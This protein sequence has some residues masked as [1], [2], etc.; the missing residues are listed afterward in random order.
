M[1]VQEK[2][3]K[4]ATR[5]RADDLIQKHEELIGARRNFES[6]WQSLHD[7]FYLESA[8]INK[9]YYPGTELDP[10]FLWDATTIESADVFA[11]GFMN[12]LTPPT[13]KWF[14]LK[15]KNPKLSENKAIGDFLEGVA[16]EVN[17]TLNRSNFYD[18][19]FPSYKSSGVY[20]TSLILEEDD[21]QDSVRFYNL[22]LKQ[23]VICEDAR[24]RPIEYYIEFEYTALQASTR[25]GADALS[26]EMQQ[27]LKAR[28]SDK[29]H[30]FVLYIGKRNI[31]EV[32]KFD[33]KNMPIEAVWIDVKA[34]KIVEEG[35]YQEFPAMAH[36]F[37]KRPFCPWG[38]SPA[39]KALPFARILNTV[40]K[41]NLRAM[42]KQTDPPVALP[43]NAFIMP[44]NAN[45]RAINYYNKD[46]M[47]GGAKDIFA[48]S[49][50]GDPN[51]GMQATEY[52][53]Q[54]VKSLMYNDVF[55]A[56]QQITKDMN[57]PE[58]MERIN[59]KM[60]MLGPAV[61][62][63]LAEVLNP[64]I[65]RTI[66]I[67]F[68][69]GKLP[70]PP[71]EMMEDPAYEIDFV[72]QLAQAQRRSELN[73]LVTGMTMVGQMAAFAPDVLDKINPDRVTDEV[74]AITGAPV[75]VLRD[76]QEIAD[77]RAN[78][79]E[80]EAKVQEMQ[81]MNAG[82]EVAMKAGKGTESFAK[83]KEVKSAK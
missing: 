73:T 34:K 30:K 19:M 14:R 64:I 31:R 11:S 16:D 56:F 45:P 60:T 81:A 65:I 36:R 70:M 68:R 41:T 69:A 15:H 27:E 22:P 66:G 17:Y 7:Y 29:K 54:K 79:R 48:F 72:G 24:G 8:D 57:N 59:E 53:S 28:A 67:L 3:V 32:Q 51:I 37:D 61:G 20:G 78:R 83:A 44:F 43:N 40:A 58:V 55:L 5:S 82:A 46:S 77:I 38:F 80:Q 42:M 76:D 74:W 50:F 63:Y 33:K 4:A 26:E 75:Q 13:S 2:E 25:W 62:R 21:L 49:N 1:P 10:T 9:S 35:G 39:M 6:Y 23:C 47:S 71:D 18:Q 12:Y 52:Y